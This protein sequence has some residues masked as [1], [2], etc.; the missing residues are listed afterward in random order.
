MAPQPEDQFHILA[1]GVMRIAVGGNHRFA[2]EETEGAG[3]DQI[4]AQAPEEEGPQVLDDLKPHQ[5]T[6]GG[7]RHDRPSALAQRVIDHTNNPPC[8]QHVTFQ[9]EGA[10]HAQE[11]IGFDQRV[12]IHRTDEFP[13]GQL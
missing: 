11:G 2:P 10:Y 6:P 5:G 4:P 12:G 3:D 13:C 9:E 7:R 8:R 1:H